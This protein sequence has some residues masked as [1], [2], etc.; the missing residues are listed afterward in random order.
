MDKLL[1]LTQNLLRDFICAAIGFLLILLFNKAL[2]FFSV[3]LNSM[4]GLLI[5]SLCYIFAIML[6]LRLRRYYDTGS[7]TDDLFRTYSKE[8][9][10]E[11]QKE[12]IE[13]LRE[14]D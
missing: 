2:L 4:F 8:Q 5:V 6:S 1:T 10:I 14:K 11:K 12:L 3:N 7:L 13:I 9:V